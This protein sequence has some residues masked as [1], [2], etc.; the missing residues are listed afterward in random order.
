[1]ISG[2]FDHRHGSVWSPNRWEGAEGRIADSGLA[3][4]HMQNIAKIAG[5][6]ANRQPACLGCPV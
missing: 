6:S 4:W 3:A 1:M 5:H 2:Q